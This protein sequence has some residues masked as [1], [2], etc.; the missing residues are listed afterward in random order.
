MQLFINNWSA[1]LSAPAASADAQL[2]VN[3]ALAA[4]L[5]GLGA[6]SYYLLTLALLDLLG[7]EVAVEAVK[8]TAQ[9][10][11]VLSVERGQEGTTARDWAAGA[12]VSA[13][14]TAGSMANILTELGAKVSVVEGFGLSERSF[15]PTEKTKLQNLPSNFAAALWSPTIVDTA[16]ARVLAITDAGAYV[17]RSNAAANTVT[18]PPQAGVEWLANTEVS[19]RNAGTGALTLTPGAGVTLNAP[20]GGTLVMGAAMTATLKRVAADVWDVIGQTV[21]A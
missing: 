14:L 15:T 18:V 16:A 21:A 17:R 8:V 9:A 5:L 3:P 13:R 2:S 19:L 7:V 11:G 1:S 10:A 4:K 20:S 12:S 6:G